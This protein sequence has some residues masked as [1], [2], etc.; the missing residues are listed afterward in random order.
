MAAARCSFGTTAIGRRKPQ[1]DDPEGDLKN[2]HLKFVLDGERMTGKWAPDRMR[3]DA[4]LKRAD[5]WKDLH[6]SAS[7]LDAARQELA[8]SR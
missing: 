4:L 5:P 3:D 8:K 7:S 6:K 1:D 2:G